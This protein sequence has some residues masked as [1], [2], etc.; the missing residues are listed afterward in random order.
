[1]CLLLVVNNLHEEID[2]AASLVIEYESGTTRGWV[3][4]HNGYSSG[5]FSGRAA[6]DDDTPVGAD[7]RPT[8]SEG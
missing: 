4:P 6:G 3:H 7:G 5:F 2:M 8:S 1:L